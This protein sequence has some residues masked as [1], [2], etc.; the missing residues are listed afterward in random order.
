VSGRESDRGSQ[1]EPA[2]DLGNTRQHLPPEPCAPP[3]VAPPKPTDASLR[4]A[5]EVKEAE[6]AKAWLVIAELRRQLYIEQVMR[7]LFEGRLNDA[8]TKEALDG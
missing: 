5:L 8:L 2:R 1:P 6:L 7:G 3:T 4:A